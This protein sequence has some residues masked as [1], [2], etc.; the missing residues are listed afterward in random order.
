MD[1]HGRDHSAVE[2]SCEFE[3]I[4]VDRAELETFGKLV[5]EERAELLRRTAKSED[6]SFVFNI[7]RRIGP[8]CLEQES[9]I[10]G[11]NEILEC[12]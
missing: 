11:F 7:G 12:S 9:T 5:A 6:R 3:E 10:E 8:I 2:G 1:L 4:W